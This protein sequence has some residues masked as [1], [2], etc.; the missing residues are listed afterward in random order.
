[1]AE[2]GRESATWMPPGH[3]YSPIPSAEDIATHR[4]G[5]QRA[6]PRDLP[7]IE[8][9]EDAQ[10]ALLARLRRY[11]PDQPWSAEPRPHLRYYFDNEYFSYADAIFLQCMLRDLHPRR[12]VEVGAG[13]S[14]AA[15]LDVL[16]R[17]LGADVRL[18]CVE[19]YPERLESLTRPGDETRFDLIR[20]PTQDAPLERFLE[21]GHDDLLFVDS[22]HVSK[23]RSDV[24]RLVLDVLPSIA[25]GVVVHFHD[26]FWPFEYPL[27][28]VEEN[29]A[30]NELYLLRAFLCFNPAFEIVLFNHVIGTRYR[31]V[32]ARDFPL[33]IR[34]IG[35]S[36]W[37]RKVGDPG[38][39]PG[40][41]SLSEKRSNR[42]S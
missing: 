15:M 18:T 23:L 39:E 31:D 7:G 29:R 5:L 24:N 12:I 17:F 16:E 1:M 4:R 33:C 2:P 40:T 28:W 36:L 25:A 26:V 38:L 19:P 10:L 22:T 42:L 21:L 32:L 14:T 13:F 3:F 34:N 37:L 11:Y 6:A 27:R 20:Q 35:G 8:L 41:S 9:R 30:W